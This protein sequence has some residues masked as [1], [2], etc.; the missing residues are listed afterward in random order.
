MFLP[1][2]GWPRPI[3]RLDL[4]N[5]RA[6]QKPDRSCDF[7]SR[8]N[9][10]SSIIYVSLEVGSDLWNWQNVIRQIKCGLNVYLAYFIPRFFHLRRLRDGTV[11]FQIYTINQFRVKL[12]YRKVFKRIIVYGF[13]TDIFN[14]KFMLQLQLMASTKNF[15][16][17]I[18]VSSE[19]EDKI[20]PESFLLWIGSANWWRSIWEPLKTCSYD[21]NPG[22]MSQ[23]RDLDIYDSPRWLIIP[24]SLKR[25]P[26]LCQ[27]QRLWQFV[28]V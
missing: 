2:Q 28:P 15:S 9:A 6:A 23:Q 18:I 1:G 10:I 19:P 8:I 21:I 20:G 14:W 22:L 12:W 16:S 24:R 27:F 4:R 13:G 11:R 5:A 3:R 26:P 17:A 25:M 7:I